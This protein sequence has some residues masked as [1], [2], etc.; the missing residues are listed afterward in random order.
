MTGFSEAESIGRSCRFLQGDDHD[1]PGLEEIRAAIREQ[2]EGHAILRNYRKD[3]T[4]FWN[5][6]YIAPV[7]DDSGEVT[8]FVAAQYDITAAKNYEAELEFQANYD[9]LTALAN[10][11][12]LRDRL[13]QA[14]ANASRSGYRIWIVHVDLDRFK[15]VNDSLGHSAGD[16]LLKGLSQRL[17]T[18]VREADTVARLGSDEF[19]LLLPGWTDDTPNAGVVQRVMESVAEPF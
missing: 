16:L 6:L 4:L 2:R 13:A 10:R 1:Q 9:T 7:K 17:Q 11:N 14:I 3:G 5:D 15:F 12:L 19:V 8:H 18:V